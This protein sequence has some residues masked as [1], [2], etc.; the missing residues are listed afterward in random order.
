MG[1]T[2]DLTNNRQDKLTSIK[3]SR[4]TAHLLRVYCVF[5]D[6]TV[7]EVVT[8]VLDRELS[9]FKKRMDTLKQIDSLSV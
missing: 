6:K 9:D 5:H 3:V 8:D 2:T 4:S 1:I 7:T